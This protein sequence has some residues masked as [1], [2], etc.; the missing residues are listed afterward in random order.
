MQFK[1]VIGQPKAKE[2]FRDASQHNRLPHA[3][4][5]T[6]PEG[7]GQLAIARALSQ[8]INCLNPQQGDSC[9]ECSQCKKNQKCIH[10]D[11][12]FIYPIISA[13]ESGKQLLAE[14]SMDSFRPMI[15]KNPYATL[16]DWSQ[17]SGGENKQLIINVHEMRALKRNI[18]LKAFEASIKVIIIWYAEKMNVQAANAFLK[19]L[20]EP[21]DQTMLI[22]TCSDS[23]K[24]LTTIRSRCQQL[25]LERLDTSSIAAFMRESYQMDHSR[26]EEVASISNGSIGNALQFISDSRQELNRQFV[27]WMRVVY[28]G[29]YGKIDQQISS[30]YQESKEFQLLFLNIA[31]H[32]LRNSFLF[33]MGVSSIAP[34]SGE[35]MEF[36]SKFSS[37]V[38][39]SKIEKMVKELEET[40][41]YIAGNANAKMVWTGLSIAL[42]QIISSH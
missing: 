33:R 20:E 26:S 19:L 31:I 17:L 37:I 40:K 7:V 22:L 8:F 13:K 15:V 39:Y 18:F 6:G 30:V 38:N 29:N 14:D 25:R 11:I 10:P 3:L 35:E 5:L 23:S 36:Q 41:R 9:G 28:I 12:K 27:A 1:D 21:P 16:E 34:I 4:L 32:K 2:K 42:H 24:L